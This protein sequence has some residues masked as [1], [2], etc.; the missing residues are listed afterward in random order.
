MPRIKMS[1][2]IGFANAKQT[3]E[4][5]FPEDDDEWGTMSAEERDVKLQE[6]ANDFGSN[7]IDLAAWVVEN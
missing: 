4:Y 6:I 2:C 1:L 7:F 5:D 3:D